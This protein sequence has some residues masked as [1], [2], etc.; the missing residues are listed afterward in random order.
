ML[1]YK[2]PFLLSGKSNRIDK[3]RE[4]IFRFSAAWKLIRSW[5]DA[6]ADQFIKFVDAKSITDYIAPEELPKRLGGNF[7]EKL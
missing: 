4:N 3:C 5:I 6:E 1:I 2:M 7:D